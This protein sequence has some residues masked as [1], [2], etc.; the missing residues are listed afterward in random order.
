MSL[1]SIVKLL[2]WST[3]IAFGLRTSWTFELRRL[4]LEVSAPPELPLTTVNGWVICCRPASMS[5]LSTVIWFEQ[6]AWNTRL[7]KGPTIVSQLVVLLLLAPGEQVCQIP[8]SSVPSVTVSPEAT[9]I[10]QALV[11]P[12]EPRT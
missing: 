5:R 9:L 1:L 8:S 11:R 4:K 6:S 12:F 10:V 7:F 3:I 2:P